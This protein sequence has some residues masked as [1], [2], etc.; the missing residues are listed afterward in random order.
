[1]RGDQG[2][3]HVDHQQPIHPGARPPRSCPGPGAGQ[4]QPGQALLAGLGQALDDPPGG[5]GRGHRPEQP[6][7][8]PERGQVAQA[9]PTVGQHHRQVSHH[10][11]GPV[12]SPV[13]LPWA[14]PTVQLAWQPEPVG[15]SDQQ[16]RPGVPDQ[17]V[18]IGGDVEPYPRLGSLHP[19]GALLDWGSRPSHSRILPAQRG[20]LLI[21]ARPASS[22]HEN[23][24]LE[25]PERECS[26]QCFEPV[27]GECGMAA[28]LQSWCFG[29]AKAHPTRGSGSIVRRPQFRSSRADEGDP[30]TAL[31]R[32]DRPLRPKQAACRR[33]VIT[34]GMT[35]C[36]CRAV[37]NPRHALWPA[38]MWSPRSD[39]NRR[40]S[41]YEPDARRRPGRLQMD[42]ACSR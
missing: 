15:Q 41:D 32:P 1:M 10:L 20:H 6:G 14:R 36:R 17:P 24:G 38:V 35:A 30:S 8:V 26:A 28:K 22:T 37:S 12:P 42:R 27:N 39:S 5:R 13:W 3:V 9:V 29:C 19:Q 34:K 4:P 16:R 11:A 7:L 21:T 23:P 31:N 2:R 33:R 25:F 18:A 40:P